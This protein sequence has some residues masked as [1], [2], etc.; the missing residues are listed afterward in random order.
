MVKKITRLGQLLRTQ[1]WQTAILKKT[2]QS[3]H[4]IAGH[5]WWDDRRQNY[6][7]FTMF[8]IKLGKFS[9]QWY[10]VD[11]FGFLGSLRT[12]LDYLL[13]HTSRSCCFTFHH[14]VD[15]TKYKESHWLL[16]MNVWAPLFS[17]PCLVPAPCNLSLWHERRHPAPSPGDNFMTSAD[18][19]GVT[20]T[21]S[22]N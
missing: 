21:S 19:S 2:G 16:P 10:I 9:T 8:S 4:C 14:G 18:D 1:F 12:G 15:Q 17:L 11:L 13:D 22:A 7:A 5:D 3:V 6:T 20:W